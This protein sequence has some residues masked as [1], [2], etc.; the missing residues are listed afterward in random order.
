MSCSVLGSPARVGIQRGPS[1]CHAAGANAT[2]TLRQQTGNAYKVDVLK[3]AEN[4]FWYIRQREA[5]PI[6]T[7]SK[8]R[9]SYQISRIPVVASDHNPSSLNL[10]LVD[11]VPQALN[12]DTELTH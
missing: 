3:C 7:Q 10:Q 8:R 1:A 5:I 2:S 11:L 6:S 4:M 12:C 9:V